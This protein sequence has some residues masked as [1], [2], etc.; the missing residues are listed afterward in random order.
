MEGGVGF[1]APRSSA[2]GLPGSD[3]TAVVSNVVFI[4]YTGSDSPLVI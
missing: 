4:N 1:G 3:Q 2:I